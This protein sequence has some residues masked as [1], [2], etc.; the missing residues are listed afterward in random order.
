MVWN[1]WKGGDEYDERSAKTKSV[2][3]VEIAEMHK[4]MTV[5][6][7]NPEEASELFNKLEKPNWAPWLAAS[8]ES[9]AGRA[10]IFPR[11]QLLMKDKNG[12]YAASLS[13]NQIDWDGDPVH[14]PSWDNVAGDPTDYSKTYKPKG[15]TLVLLSMNVASLYK[16][17]QLPSKMIDFTKNVAQS[18][19]VSHLI[20]S[21]RP[22]GYGEIKRAMGYGFDFETYILMKKHGTNKPIDPWLRSLWWKGMNMLAVDPKAMT[23]EDD[24][25][26]FER[27]KRTYNPNAWFVAAP[28][29]WECGEVGNWK[30]DPTQGKAIYQESNVWG[31]LPIA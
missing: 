15:N 26:S 19:G 13:L 12:Q 18:M 6:S 25:S 3:D 1:L 23:V 21:F 31:R 7:W 29:I 8:K 14:L 27:Y 10:R 17:L 5:E 24:L 11:G 2:S 28:N 20:G 16:G 22:S 4:G 30:L 9:I